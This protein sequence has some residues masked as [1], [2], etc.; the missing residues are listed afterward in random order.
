MLLIELAER[1]VLPDWLIRLGI[2]YLL[3]VRLREEERRNKDEP[4]EFLRRFLNELRN[5][6]IAISVDA[7]NLQ[8]YE[9][10]AEFFKQVLGPRL[11][12]SCCYWPEPGTTLGQAEEAMLELFCRRAGIEDGMEIL[13]LG[14]GWGSVC[15]WISQKLPRCRI[16]AISNSNSQRAFIEARCRSLGLDN[17]EVL[18]AD[19]AAFSTSRRFDRVLSVEM[20]EHVRNYEELLGRIAAWLKPGGKLMVHIFCHARY[21]YPFEV[22]GAANWMGRHFFTGGI[23]PA[24]DLLLY[25]QRDLLLE[26]QWRISG[27]HYARTLEAWLENCDRGRPELLGLLQAGK[28]R[29]ESK[30]ELQR[31]R[32]FFMACAELFNYR[33]G[34]E[35]YVS[36]YLFRKRE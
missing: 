19:I 11:K 8:H 14:C 6:P 15:L 2:R 13:E 32:L 20:F 30:R 17:I 16:T 21:A 31:W 29:A 28:G 34:H 25:F 26:D 1:A 24:D 27:K 12:Y 4:R 9:V 5:S 36:H 18:T 35:W 22:E 23:M 7:A 33:H 3:R 10:P